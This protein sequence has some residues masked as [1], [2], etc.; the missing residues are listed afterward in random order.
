VFSSLVA[1]EIEYTKIYNS[2]STDWSINR[3]LKE[4]EKINKDF[5]PCP[6]ETPIK[7]KRV[8]T[9]D[10][11]K[12][13]KDGFLTQKDLEELYSKC[14]A[15]IHMTNPYSN[16]VDYEYYKQNI[17][18]WLEKIENLLNYHTF[19][20]VNDVNKHFSITD[21]TVLGNI[22]LTGVANPIYAVKQI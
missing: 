4:I 20:L 15:V 11:F 19:K 3:I 14:C 5:Y 18:G 10:E 17:K 22:V 9:N 16:S 6:L 8:F 13:R 12:N 1:N 7:I 2:I 21:P